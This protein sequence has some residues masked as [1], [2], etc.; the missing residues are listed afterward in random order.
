MSMCRSTRTSAGF[1]DANS[2]SQPDYMQPHAFHRPDWHP[3]YLTNA[4]RQLGSFQPLAANTCTQC[5]APVVV[6]SNGTASWLGTVG[7]GTVGLIGGAT[8][9]GLAHR[10][11]IPA[12]LKTHIGA[13]HFDN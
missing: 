10:S 8:A 2:F 4:P 7:N 3:Q 5:G 13:E 1:N 12:Y 9:V 11:G 6:T